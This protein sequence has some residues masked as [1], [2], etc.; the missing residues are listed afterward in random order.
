[1]EISQGKKNVLLNLRTVNCLGMSYW[2]A[3][4]QSSVYSKLKILSGS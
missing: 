3:C 1:M 4:Y 2:N